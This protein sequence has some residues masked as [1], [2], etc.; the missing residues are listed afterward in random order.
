[1]RANRLC[2]TAM[3]PSLGNA[4]DYTKWRRTPAPTRPAVYF[5][6]LDCFSLKCHADACGHV[7]GLVVGAAEFTIVVGVDGNAIAQ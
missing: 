5:L 7:V 3:R 4:S 2:L 1:M 6:R